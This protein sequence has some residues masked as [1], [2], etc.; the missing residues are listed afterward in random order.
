MTHT[1]PTLPRGGKRQEEMLMTSV[2]W[3]TPPSSAHRSN[4]S[5]M[6]TVAT[7]PVWGSILCQPMRFQE[8]GIK[9]HIDSLVYNIYVQHIDLCMYVCSYMRLHN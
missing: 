3:L 8:D 9:V 2:S 1:I 4:Q 7:P 6:Q 5:E